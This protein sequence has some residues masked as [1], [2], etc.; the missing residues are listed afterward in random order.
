M[1]NILNIDRKKRYLL[2]S[3]L[4][5]LLGYF[6][7][8]QSNFSL[9]TEIFLNLLF[10]LVFVSISHYP[11]IKLH[12][13]LYGS[14]LPIQLVLS[15]SLFF[16]FYPNLSYLFK[17][18]LLLGFSFLYYVVSLVDN[19]FL[20]IQDRE[21]Q[22]PMYRVASTWAQILVVI[23][24]I[25]LYSSIFKLDILFIWQSILVLISTLLFSFYQFWILRF[26]KDLKKIKVGE[27]IL[28]NLLAGFLVFSTSLSISFFP[29]ES[30]LRALFVSSVL[31]F[32][33]NYTQSHLKND[34]NEKFLYQS[35][36]IS[37]FFFIILVLFN[38]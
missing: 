6:L 11:N 19:I 15:G 2:Q 27:F 38:P 1:A 20:V 21:E 16:Y 3:L 18:V 24:S 28:L 33:L 32:S 36:F 13:I 14:I 34:V 29:T 31:M 10:V 4:F 12:N 26:D 7:F 30:F 17:S 22:I 8:I 37:L 23:T 5:F 9:V 35:L 25:P